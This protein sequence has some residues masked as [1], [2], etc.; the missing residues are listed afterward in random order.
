M[1]FRVASAALKAINDK[2]GVVPEVVSTSGNPW[3]LISVNHE[4]CRVGRTHRYS[5]KIVQNLPRRGALLH[6]CRGVSQSAWDEENELLLIDLSDNE[7]IM[8]FYKNKKP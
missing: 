6:G 5:L 4:V 3:G 7:E 2:S 1:L 8:N